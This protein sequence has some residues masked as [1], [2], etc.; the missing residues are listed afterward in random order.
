MKP[1]EASSHETLAVAQAGMLVD[2]ANPKPKAE[3]LE[4]K[5]MLKRKRVMEGPYLG[6]NDWWVSHV[7]KVAEAEDQLIPTPPGIM[8]A[9]GAG[10]SQ[11]SSRVG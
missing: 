7:E 8:M 3:K 1:G 10:G 11:M 5:S 6:P 9:Q 4:Q 2:G